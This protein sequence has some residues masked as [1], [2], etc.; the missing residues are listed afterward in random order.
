MKSD[1]SRIQ[2][3]DFAGMPAYTDRGHLHNGIDMRR[4]SKATL[5]AAPARAPARA[6]EPAAAAGDDDDAHAAPPRSPTAT[7]RECAI[8]PLVAA[9]VE[10]SRDARSTRGSAPPHDG[11]EASQSARRRPARFS[12]LNGEALMGSVRRVQLTLRSPTIG[13]GRR[14]ARF[15]MR[16]SSETM[17]EH[18]DT[19]DDAVAAVAAAAGR[20]R[21]GRF[22]DVQLARC[23]TGADEDALFGAIEGFGAGCV[24]FNGWMH[25][26]VSANR[27][28][29]GCT[30]WSPPIVQR[31]DARAGLRQSDG[32][33]GGRGRGR[34]R[35]PRSA[36]PRRGS[37]RGGAR[38]R[39][40]GRG[41][42][43]GRRR[44]RAAAIV[45]PR[46]PGPAERIAAAFWRIAAAF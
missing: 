46:S 5:H 24:A 45:G 30:R 32:A 41:A 29:A 1:A 36:R 10:A 17:P 20:P 34:G 9:A 28:T 2:L 14:R 23:T 21:L 42:G 6:A 12:I 16:R 4:E 37:R 38:W 25:A 39:C 43:A 7:A 8:P 44:R 35:G 3:R 40:R 13:G 18:A 11:V 15:A 19:A 27:S 31:L 26:L 22:F 33:V